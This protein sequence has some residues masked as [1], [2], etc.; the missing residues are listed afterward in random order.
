MP[1]KETLFRLLLVVSVEIALGILIALSPS[2]FSRLSS[3]PWKS[4]ISSVSVSFFAAALLSATLEPLARKQTREE[5]NRALEDAKDS[6][7]NSLTKEL[8]T[9]K[10][11][12]KKN[13]KLL[14]RNWVKS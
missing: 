1:G 9:L 4:L 7:K 3:E 14:A 11:K 6:A 12:V 13:L 5:L 10:K 8:E 2:V